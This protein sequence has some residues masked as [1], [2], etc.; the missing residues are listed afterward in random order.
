[1]QGGKQRVNQAKETQAK[2]THLNFIRTHVL[3][4]DFYTLSSLASGSLMALDI[5][6][7][8]E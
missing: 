4:F 6:L 5:F 7:S 2:G 8:S 3:L 1:M